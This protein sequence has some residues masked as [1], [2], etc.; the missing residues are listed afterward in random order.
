MIWLL[1]LWH[2]D[3]KFGILKIKLHIQKSCDRRGKKYWQL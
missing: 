2:E 3:R 1:G